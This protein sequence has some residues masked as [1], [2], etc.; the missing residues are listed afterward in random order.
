LKN[1]RSARQAGPTRHAQRALRVTSQGRLAVRIT[2][3]FANN[4]LGLVGTAAIR[5]WMSTV[6]HKLACYDPAVDPARAECRAQ[7]IYIFWHE[8]ILAPLFLRGRCNLTMLLSRHRDAELLSRIAFHFGFG[9]IRGSS[10]RGS[11]Q[12]LREMFRE[13]RAHH[14][15]ITPDGPRGPRRQLA[16]GPIYL[17]SK[18]S[19][20][21]VCVGI[22]YDRPWRMRTWDRFAIP[23]PGSRSRI[24]L[25]PEIMIPPGLDRDGLESHR[26]EIERLLNRLTLEAEAWAEAGT[27]KLGETP[28]FP[29]ATERCRGLQSVG[30]IEPTADA[31]RVHLPP[32]A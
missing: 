6:E 5:G 20:P 25:S 18:L 1:A 23:R 31:A 26:R 10:Y 8:Y 17:A 30:A 32:A 24:V 19:L 7:K 2:S 28:L 3:P 12:A 22:G 11:T 21:L 14:L 9:C 29:Q 27:A 4:L 15:T 16:A 13:S